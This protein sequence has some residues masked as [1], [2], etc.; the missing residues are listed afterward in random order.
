MYGL[1]SNTDLSFLVGKTLQQVC[2]GLHEIILNFDDPLSITIMS[3]I[4]CTL[5]GAKYQKY[6]DYRNAASV[7][8]T[9]LQDVVA[10]AKGDQ[11]GTLTLEF[12][13]GGRLDVYDDSKQYESYIIKN[14]D[15]LIVV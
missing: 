6:E 4:A 7:V 10:S 3:P 12:G 5:A 11:D 8:V 1:P 15:K 2:I 14:G 13:G 9:F